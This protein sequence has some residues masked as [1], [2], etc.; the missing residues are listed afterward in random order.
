MTNFNRKVLIVGAGPVGMT[1][2]I[3]LAMKGIPCRIIDKREKPTA[4]LRAIGISMSSEKIF[5]DIGVLKEI[6]KKGF[7][8]SE[9]HLSHYSYGKI[10][11]EFGKICPAISGYLHVYQPSIEG[12]LV[13]KLNQLGIEIGRQHELV[14]L[15]D[16]G[17]H[18][19]AEIATKTGTREYSEYDYVIGC[20][21]AS[22][23]VSSLAD[24]ETEEKLYKYD[25]VLTDVSLIEGSSLSATYWHINPEGYLA[26]LPGPENRARVIFS[27]E[28]EHPALTID[29]T[30]LSNFVKESIG[31]SLSFSEILWEARG[32]FRHKRAICGRKGNI[33]LAGDSYHIFSPIGGLNMNFGLQDAEYL[34]R[35]LFSEKYNEERSPKILETIK[36]T[37]FLTRLMAEPATHEALWCGF[38]RK[39]KSDNS[40]G[41][42]V[43]ANF[44]GSQ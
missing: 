12:I 15:K 9:L 5:S 32:L 35:K 34:S 11:L 10:E 31:L 33:F 30:Y 17:A 2:A 26:V 6:E 42:K 36:F 19:E 7:R 14:A 37:E 22:G 21:G 25:F 44:L 8:V 3:M 20:D 23:V 41:K 18:I 13:E 28:H 29:P 38:I 16:K 43:F 24:F 40:F 1:L 27:I 4:L 39:L